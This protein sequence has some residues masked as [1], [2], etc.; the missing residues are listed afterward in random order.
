MTDV[1]AVTKSSQLYHIVFSF[2]GVKRCR[3]NCSY[4]WTF[5]RLPMKLQ[6]G[7]VF[8]G[9]H[10]FTGKRI[11]VWP[12]PTMPWTSLYRAPP[13]P[14]HITPW[15]PCPSSPPDIRPGTPL[16][17]TSGGQHW[18]P[19]Q[20]CSLEDLL[21]TDIWWCPLKHIQFATV[22]KQAVSILLECF[23]VNDLDAEKCVLK[24]TKSCALHAL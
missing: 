18:K 15:T 16:L 14:P 17:L 22:C 23:L 9:F 21:R 8:T 7:N 6:E 24:S 3:G 19:V 20:T 5:Y 12:L 13:P 10:L 2:Q 4:N 1:T 11:P